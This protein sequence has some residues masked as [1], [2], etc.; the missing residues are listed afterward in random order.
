MTTMMCQINRRGAYPLRLL[1]RVVAV[2]FGLDLGEGD[3]GGCG[4]PLKRTVGGCGGAIGA[5]LRNRDGQKLIRRKDQVI[6]GMS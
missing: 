5:R 2:E 3:R 1:L 4:R 6:G